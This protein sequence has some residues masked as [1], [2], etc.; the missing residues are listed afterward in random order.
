MSR[1]SSRVARALATFGLTTRDVHARHAALERSCAR[2]ARRLVARDPAVTVIIGPSGSG[3]STLLRALGRELAR[4]GVARVDAADSL[5]GVPEDR[6][7]V[8]IEGMSL[9]ASLSLLAR[10]GLGEA[11]LLGLLPRQL[12]D[13]QRARL[14]LAHAL[15][16]ARR[17]RDRAGRAWVMID[18][19]GAGLDVVTA[20][21]VARAVARLVRRSD[22]IGVVVCAVSEE[23]VGEVEPDAAVRT[24]LARGPRVVFMERASSD[25]EDRHALG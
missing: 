18:E 11:R 24:S 2:A 17:E 23:A 8:E 7:I 16:R 6:A 5:A 20:R 15:R 4:A 21:G 3:K 1:P 10:V 19:F 9:P 13:G 25:G 14:A 12:S 22:G